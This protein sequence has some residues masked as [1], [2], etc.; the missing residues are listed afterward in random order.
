MIARLVKYG[1]PKQPI[2]VSK[3]AWCIGSVLK[4]YEDNIT[5]LT[6]SKSE[7][8]ILCGSYGTIFTEKTE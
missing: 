3:L 4:L 8:G 6:T 1:F 7:D 5:V 2:E